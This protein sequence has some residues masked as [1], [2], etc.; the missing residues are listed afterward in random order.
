MNKLRVKRILAWSLAIFWMFLIFN[1]SSQV[2]EDSNNLSNAIAVRIAIIVEKV[3]PSIEL[4]IDYVNHLFRKGAHFF[5]YLLL[6]I[7]VVRVLSLSKIH[8][9]RLY[10]LTFAIC[11]IYAI[12]DELHQGF[13]P[14][15]GPQVFDV[16]IDSTGSFTGVLI[17]RSWVEFKKKKFKS[18][19]SYQ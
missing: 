6:G 7:L 17:Y 3:V 8:G 12:T 18:K 11:I 5:S 16:L 10:I 1:M 2:R 13:V 19:N 15:R 9:R 4:D 14:G